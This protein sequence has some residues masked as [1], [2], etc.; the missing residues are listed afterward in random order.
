MD[1]SA[2]DF[3]QSTQLSSSSSPS[4]GLHGRPLP[5]LID[6]IEDT[7]IMT[8]SLARDQSSSASG[9]EMEESYSMSQTSVRKRD[10]K[11]RKRL[12]DSLRIASK[13][14][15]EDVEEKRLRLLSNSERNA[16]RRSQETPQV[17]INRLRK[18][19][20]NMFSK[21]SSSTA[22]EQEKRRDCERDRIRDKRS[23]EPEDVRKMRSR[24]VAQR[25]CA[26]K[27]QETIAQ[28]LARRSA[29][30]ASKAKSS[31]A[32]LGIAASNHRPMAHYLG[33]MNQECSFCKA[34]YFKVETTKQ[35]KFNSCCMGGAVKLEQKPIPLALKKLFLT[36]KDSKNKD[37]WKEAKNFK[38]NCRQYNNS[39]AMAYMKYQSDEQMKKSGG[40]WCFRLHDQVYHLIGNLHP[41][42]NM[43]RQFAQIFIMDTEQAAAE[44]AGQEKNSSCSKELFGKL[45]DILQEHHPHTKSFKMMYEVEK[46]EKE[47]AAAENRPERNVTMVFQIRSQDDQRRYQNSTANEVAVVYVG[48]D[49][50][51]PGKRGTTVYKRGGG[52]R[53]MH[54][55]D[56]NCDPMTYPLFFPTGQFGWSIDIE[57]TRNRGTKTNVTMREFYS[58][59]LHVRS[60]FS[61]LFRGGKLYQQYVVEKIGLQLTEPIFSH[62]QLYVA[63]SRTTTK[64]G[65]RIEAPSGK[66][67]NVVYSEVLQ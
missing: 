27:A 67:N 62:G 39:L 36:N 5:G 41:E 45:I 9:D 18:I 35:G 63:L 29:D 58:Y 22:E 16:I 52:L 49:D 50:E 38:E 55:I 21:R 30:L 8:Q 61:P 34:Q 15:S 11:K 65:I 60:S 56:R 48:D 54:I 57:Y 24:A 32:L 37:L 12:A 59:H 44:L 64:E 3:T 33:R 10:R 2:S 13:R 42:N 7:Q 4:V 46:E 20:E 19:N 1:P 40:P 6:G 66:M 31:G 25:S 14:K 47:K 51:I 17:K 28:T 23:T 43:R 53:F 26:V